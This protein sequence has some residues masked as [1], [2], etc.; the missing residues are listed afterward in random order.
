M[1]YTVLLIV[2]WINCVFC[3]IP[4]GLYVDNGLDQTT[5]ERFISK[6]EKREMEAEILSLLGLPSR[7]RK[8]INSTLRKSAPKFLMDVYKS[9]METENS[10]N[11]RSAD[12]S[13]TGEEKTAID[14]SDLIMT[15]ESISKLFVQNLVDG[16]ILKI[17]Y[18]YILKLI[19]GYILILIDGHIFILINGYIHKLIDGYILKLIPIR[20]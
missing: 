8:N 7:P 14:E 6:A 16:Y 9:I 3:S 20:K 2:L 11:E 10:R 5:I 12:I 17:I 4:A 19:D 1:N 13:L 18:R 15:F